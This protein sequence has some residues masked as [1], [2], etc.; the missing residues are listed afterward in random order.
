[1]ETT[2]KR[3]S[4]IRIVLTWLLMVG[5][6]VFFVVLGFWRGHGPALA[7][8]PAEEPAGIIVHSVFSLFV[9]GFFLVLGVM[10]YLAVIFTGCFTFSYS[11]PVWDGVK[12]RKFFANIIVTVLL[13]LGTGFLLAA[14]LGPVLVALGLDAGMANMLPVML[15]VVGVQVVQLWVL[16]WSPIERRIILKRLAAQ[17]ITPAQ[18]QSAALVGLSNPASGIAK[19]F[20]AI[21]EDMGAL[22]IQPD[23]LMYRGDTEQ[24]DITRQQLEQMERK[25]DNRS[26]SVLGG[27]AHVILHVRLPDGGIR[28]IRLHTEGQ[29]TMGRK[30][31]AMDALAGAIAGWQGGSR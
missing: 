29:W 31:Q 1:M 9:G 13:A 21:E 6:I 26:T 22:W 28:Q 11:Q 5:V 19:R 16:I 30:R 15:M 12:T 3:P 23:L 7:T 27:I 25:A 2:D 10:S 4:K 8:G 20:G 14:F 24:F 18:L 17:G